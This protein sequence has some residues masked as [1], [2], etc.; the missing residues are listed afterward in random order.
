MTSQRFNLDNRL[1]CK[2]VTDGSTR[3]SLKNKIGEKRDAQEDG[4]NTTTEIRD[5]CQDMTV[6]WTDG[7]SG[8][9]LKYN[10]KTAQCIVYT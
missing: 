3:D 5:H 2:S 10:I 9:I 1:C 7:G 8:N 4:G 6:I